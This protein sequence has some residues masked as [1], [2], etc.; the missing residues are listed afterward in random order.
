M[1]KHER[2]GEK[3]REFE[4]G[5]DE[6]WFSN[7]K[8]TYDE[9][10]QESLQTIREMRDHYAKVASDAQSHDNDL[11]NLTIQAMQNAVETANMLSKS[12]VNLFNIAG[13]RMWNIDEVSGLAAK[14][15]VW[16]DALAASLASAIADALHKEQ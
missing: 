7:I 13:D 10:Q 8:R 5:K 14:T 1:F 11:R 6:A 16:L 2:D 4:T 15:P 3:E 12:A 9:F